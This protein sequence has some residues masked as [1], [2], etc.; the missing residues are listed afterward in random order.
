MQKLSILLQPFGWSRIFGM[1]PWHDSVRDT[2]ITA[3][4][5][6]I[7]DLSIRCLLKIPVSLPTV[8]VSWKTKL[9][10]YLFIYLQLAN[11]LLLLNPENEEYW[12]GS[13]NSGKQVWHCLLLWGGG[14]WFASLVIF[15]VLF[16]FCNRHLYENGLHAHMHCL[17]RCCQFPEWIYSYCRK[18]NICH[19][20]IH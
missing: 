13:I 19:T 3:I 17:G 11:K 16:L 14:C 18:C 15:A 5:Q 1:K 6:H 7:A 12:V 2:E 10:I 9:E 8:L 20:W 4:P